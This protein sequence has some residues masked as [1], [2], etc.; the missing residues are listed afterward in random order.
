MQNADLAKETTYFEDCV[1]VAVSYET[2]QQ[3]S[4]EVCWNLE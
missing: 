4:N 1:A 3:V 2:R